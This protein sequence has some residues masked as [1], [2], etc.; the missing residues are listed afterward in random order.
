[1]SVRSHSTKRRRAA[2]LAVGALL[3]VAL[4]AL[5][6]SCGNNSG[7]GGG[8]SSTPTAAEIVIVA[9]ASMSGPLAGFG[10]YEKWALETVI[11]D[12]NAKG[13]VTVDGVQHKVKGVLI[14]D[15][16]DPN[17]AASNID[18]LVTKNGAVALLG[19]VTPTVGNAAS[20]AA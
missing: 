20:L 16:S 12:M 19:P 9:D 14:D 5:A 6:A 13:G 15:K 18:T 4:L 17:V 3:V 10:A 8:G 2:L 1:M 7:W 11:A